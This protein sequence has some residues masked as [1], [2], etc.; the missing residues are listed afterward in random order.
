MD[1]RT[2]EQLQGTLW[3][4]VK[5]CAFSCFLIAGALLIT[6][7]FLPPPPLGGFDA[8]QPPGATRPVR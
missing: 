7:L 6:S 1:L 3:Q 2:T 5:V 4:H 8:G